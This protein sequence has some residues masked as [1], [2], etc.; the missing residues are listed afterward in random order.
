MTRYLILLTVALS[1][2]FASA[3]V[4][5]DGEYS[6]K[7]VGVDDPSYMWTQLDEKYGKAVLKNNK[8]M[9]ES[10]NDKMP[11]ISCTEF[12]VNPKE[13]DFI[14]EF[15][16]KPLDWDD[17]KTIGIV[18]DYKNER[19]YSLITLSKKNFVYQ[20]CE[21]GEMSVVKRGVYKLV[22]RKKISMKDIVSEYE[23]SDVNDNENAALLAF[24]SDK[25]VLD[26]KLV[27]E[28]GILSLLINDVEMAQF[29]NVDMQYPAMGFYV[30]P[31]TKME[32]YGISF[33]TISYEKDDEE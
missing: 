6:L 13:E 30:G 25:N 28:H 11:V 27:K 3:E 4:K 1:Y 21:K 5:T 18:F 26:V 8:L 20:V 7:F 12:L 16:F 33:S 14:A 17:K 29:R 22:G 23:K 19:N 32:A 24:L 10:K 9:L 15:V 2:M 31:K